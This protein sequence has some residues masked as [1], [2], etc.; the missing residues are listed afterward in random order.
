MKRCTECDSDRLSAG[1]QPISLEVG[2]RSFEGT[3]H[4][5][6]CEACGERYY[7]GA[8]LEQFEQLAARW[9]AEH[10]VRTY[11]ELRFMRKAAG[12]RAADLAAWI[13]VT[14]E[15]VSHWETGKTA[16][17]VA[18]RAAIASIV[19]DLLDRRTTMRDR[20]AAHAKP[21]SKRKVRLVRAA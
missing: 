10:G 12:I 20:L 7:P 21:D 15:T 17:D 18:S 2:E 8:E 5:W 11:A 4:G 14:P 13:G 3:V 1:E 16:P 9:L 6:H 19:L